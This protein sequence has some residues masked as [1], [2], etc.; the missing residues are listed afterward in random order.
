MLKNLK[1]L[2][3]VVA[4]LIGITPFISF[5]SVVANADTLEE[6]STSQSTENNELNEVDF[7][8]AVGESVFFSYETNTFYVDSVIALT[9]GLNQWNIDNLNEW[10]VVMNEDT[11]LINEIVNENNNVIR[12][13]ALPAFLIAALKALGKG[14]LSVVGG[15]V[16]KY[17]MKG[18]CRE[19]GSKYA[20]FRDFCS[21]NDFPV[22]GGGGR[23]F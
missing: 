8:R 5:G 19:V 13:F 12:P 14:A 11:K 2:S 6:Q 4:L 9:N 3:F 7:E 20:P 22:H 23:D 1:Y 10:V 21:A 17:G 16:A 18:A 15:A